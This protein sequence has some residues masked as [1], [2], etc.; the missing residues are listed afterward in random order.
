MSIQGR[1][2]ILVKMVKQMRTFDEIKNRIS[3]LENT[4]NDLECKR[5]SSKSIE[6]REFIDNEIY[7]ARQQINELKWVLGEGK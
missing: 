3:V 1:L 7:T 2:E 4:I 5:S 6:H